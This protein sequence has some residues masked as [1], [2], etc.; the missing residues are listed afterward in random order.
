MAGIVFMYLWKYVFA[1]LNGIACGYF[2]CSS[3]CVFVVCLWVH[4]LNGSVWVL[5][6][7]TVCVWKCLCVCAHVL[8][9]SVWGHYVC[10]CVHV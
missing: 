7:L 5:D 4:V 9:G 6:L 10:V 3:V 2:S 8:N 1:F